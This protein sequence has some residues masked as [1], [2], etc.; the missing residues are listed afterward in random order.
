VSAGL[1]SKFKG[2]NYVFDE[3]MG[4][5]ITD[6]VLSQCQTCGTPHDMF[7]NCKNCSIRFLQCKSCAF[8]LGSCCSTACMDSYLA[9]LK[10]KERLLSK[11]HERAKLL[12]Q[13]K[14]QQ[15]QKKKKKKKSDGKNTFAKSHGLPSLL[16][17]GSSAAP[18]LPLPLLL[19][20]AMAAAAV[21]SRTTSRPSCHTA[22]CFPARSLLC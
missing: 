19:P 1:A 12:Q 13:G 8:D 18:S 20:P 6:D 17:P 14:Q 4:E 2:V 22:R 7:S 16:L 10:N 11:K 21:A 5:R 9:S 15:H 3:R